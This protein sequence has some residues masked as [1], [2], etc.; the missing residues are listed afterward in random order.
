MMR[1]LLTRGIKVEIAIKVPS[2]K[3]PYTLQLNQPP[4][5]HQHV[6][7][8]AKHHRENDKSLSPQPRQSQIHMI[9]SAG[10]I[11]GDEPK[12]IEHQWPTYTIEEYYSTR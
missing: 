6:D 3:G 4:S 7:A 2:T 12:M 5:I 1:L 10:A 9:D 11:S 8:R